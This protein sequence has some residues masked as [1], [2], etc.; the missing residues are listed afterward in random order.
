MSWLSRA[1]CSTR[2]ASASIRSS[3]I[4]LMELFDPI[5][6]VRSRLDDERGAHPA[7]RV[8]GQRAP[9][10]PLPGAQLGPQLGELAGRRR[11]QLERSRA[12]DSAQAQVVCVLARVVELDARI[13]GL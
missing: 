3:I 9:E 5:R 2:L 1:A 12:A 10:L 8:L 11:R 13:A 4:T 7:L 6:P